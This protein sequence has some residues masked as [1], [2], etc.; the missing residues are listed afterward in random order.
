M[1]TEY[2]NKMLKINANLAGKKKGSIIQIKTRNGKPI[3]RYWKDRLEE[4]K[5]DSCV[6]WVNFETETKKIGGKKQK[7]NDAIEDI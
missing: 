5:L 3:D 6:E 1:I 7:K 4:S 2:E